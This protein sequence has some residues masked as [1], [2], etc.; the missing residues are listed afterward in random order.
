METTRPNASGTRQR[1]SIFLAPF[2]LIVLAVAV[3][4]HTSLAT[5]NQELVFRSPMDVLDMDPAQL[6]ATL[7]DGLARDIYSGL[8]KYAGY[9]FAEVEP[10]LA[11]EWTISE[12]GRVY[13]FK[14]REGVEWHHG[15][16]EVTA[17]DVKFSMERLVDPDVASHHAS[18]AA[19]IERVEVINDYEVEFHLSEPFPAFLSEF[20]A[21]RPGYI[22]SEAAIE[23]RGET[24]STNPVGSGPFVW[25]D[26]SPRSEIILEANPD[27]YGDTGALSTVRVVIIEQDSLF[28][29]SLER[30]DVDIG[31]V[32]DADV[33]RSVLQNDAIKTETAPAAQ[34]MFL[35]INGSQAPFDDPRVRQALW[36]AI[37][38]EALIEFV[39]NGLGEPSDTIMNPYVFGYL[40]GIV[41]GYDPERALELLEEAGHPDGFQATI[42]VRPTQ[43][44][45][46]QATA[47][48]SMWRQV[49]IDIEIIGPIEPAQAFERM[50][51]GDFDIATVAMMR[52][53]PDQYLRPLLHSDSIPFLNANRYDN[54][55]F[56]ELVDSAQREGDE[57]LRG[58]LYHEA[59]RT[60]QRDAPLI[61]LYHP[62]HVLAMQP[63]V[64]G[65]RI[66]G[67]QA[68]ILTEIYKSE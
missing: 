36:Y 25:T 19:I 34:T 46:Q 33:Q 54:P 40:E 67:I 32:T 29:L 23:D 50:E 5:A 26:W 27:Y 51:Q 64:S 57:E 14:L 38:K 22:V 12:D 53:G 18:D 42:M 3:A 9:D 10:D 4:L 17:N 30:G 52:L 44:E 61:P 49:G 6:R 62:T 24:F 41:Y 39:L 35:M 56:D 21:Y 13:T 55:D 65:A 1:K 7:D 68:L 20:L 15:Y 66:P 59:Q 45:P 43:N 2:I 58:Q 11:T 16:G 28:E 48:Q 60:L 63:N 8:V 31:Y 37:D 47:L